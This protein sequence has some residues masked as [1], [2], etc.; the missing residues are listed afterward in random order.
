MNLVSNIDQLDYYNTPDQWDCYCEYLA[1]PSDLVLQDFIN[2]NASSGFDLKVFVMSADGLTTY[3]EATSFFSWYIFTVG[4]QR[5]YNLRLNSYSDAMC[6]NLCWILRIEITIGEVTKYIKYTNRY[7]QTICCDVPRGITF[8]AAGFSETQSFAETVPIPMGQ[9]GSPLIRIQV[10]FDCVNNQL[11]EYFALPTNVLQG[12]ASFSFIKI[13]NIAGQILQKPSDITRTISYNCTLQRSEV[14]KVY[15]IQSTGV[16]GTFPRWKLNELQGMFTAPVIVISDFIETK[17]YQFQGGTIALVPHDCWDIYRLQA[18]LQSCP[19]RQT[20]GC[21]ENCEEINSLTFLVPQSYAG[22]SFYSESQQQIGNYSDL[23]LYY[24]AFGQVSDVDYPN[25]YNGFTVTGSGYIPTNF[26]FDG[27]IPRNRVYG[28]NNP[29]APVIACDMPVIGTPET[30]EMTC[31]V[32]VLGTEESHE[33]DGVA[34]IANILDWE[35]DSDSKVDLS[36]RWGRMNLET[37]NDLVIEES[38]LTYFANEPI[39]KIEA[40]GA[41]N[42]AQTFTQSDNPSIPIDSYVV[43]D[44]NGLITYSGYPTSYSGEGATIT[45]TNLYYLL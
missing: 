26:Y 6:E 32:P 14:F 30:Y 3:E 5:L 20:F 43:I 29:V 19:I 22:G 39:G 35:V 38:P 13:T 27:I 16:A 2:T 17:Q 7:C 12:T 31:A 36:P 34:N 15:D 8:E 23:L 28:T 18:V 11:G 9:C 42:V 10:E 25:T 33:V 41:P 44:T 21:N 40:L 1:Y 4:S 45:I 24:A 37:T